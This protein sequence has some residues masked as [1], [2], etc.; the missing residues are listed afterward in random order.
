MSISDKYERLGKLGEGSYGIVYKALDRSTNQMVALKR[1]KLDHESSEGIPGTT[2][3][4]VV[5]LKRLN[6]KYVVRLLD[7]VMDED[8]YLVFEFCDSDLHKYLSTAQWVSA[9]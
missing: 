7:I 5:L 4:E 9:H 1:I 8:L 2:L 3:R 6:C